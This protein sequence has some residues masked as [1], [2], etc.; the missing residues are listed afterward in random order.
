VPPV[1]L[2]PPIASRVPLGC[3]FQGLSVF[4]AVP[5]TR[6]QTY[7]NAS[8]AVLFTISLMLP[9]ISANLVL[10]DAPS[11]LLQTNASLGPQEHPIATYS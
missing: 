5:S 1:P 3:T 11:A 9:I 4:P 10:Q 7:P 6:S 2:I 8:S